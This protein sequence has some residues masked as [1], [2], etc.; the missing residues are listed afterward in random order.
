MISAAVAAVSGIL[1]AFLTDYALA[2]H[3]NWRG[4]FLGALVPAVILFAGL[5]FLP[6]SPR[7]LVNAGR[8][9]EA[10]AVLARTHRFISRSLR[11]LT[12]GGV[13]HPAMIGGRRWFRYRRRARPL[14]S[15]QCW[16]ETTVRR[17][18]AHVWCA[19]RLRARTQ[20][21]LRLQALMRS[22]H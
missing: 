1:I 5:W 20:L 16:L 17:G 3:N 18:F 4:M 13:W 2:S 14:C 21:C 22:R 19:A 15:P 11:K 8:E 7:W 12:A 10:R 6:E 9:D